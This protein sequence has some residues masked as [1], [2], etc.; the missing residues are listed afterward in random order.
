[1][2]IRNTIL[3]T[4]IAAA[5]TLFQGCSDDDQKMPANPDAPV[6]VTDATDDIIYE[7]NPRFYGSSDCLKAVNNDLDNIA[8]TGANVIWLM[9]VNTPGQLNS[10]G[11]PYCVSDFKGVNPKFG[12][13]DDLKNLVAN[14]HSRGMKVILDWIANHTAWDCAWIEDH[15]DWY[16]Q[17]GAGNIISPAGTSWTDVADL[18]YDN[19]AMRQAMI[20]AMTYW[21]TAAD[22]DGYRC[23][24]VDGVP[25]DFWT[26]AI[27]ALREKKAD[28]FMLA[29]SSDPAYFDAGFDMNYGWN[30]SSK[31][32][33][34][35]N[36]KINASKLI[37]ESAKD[38]NAL[39]DG[40][41]S[42]RYA[43]NHDVAA[44]KSASALYGSDDAMMAAQV[45]AAMLDASP[46]VYSGQ[47]V[48]Y[49]GTLSFFDYSAKTFNQAKINELKAIAAAYKAT[50]AQRCGQ[51][52]NYQAGNAL[53]FGRAVA[54]SQVLVIVN[55]TN[56]ALTVK[57]PIALAASSMTDALT[58]QSTVLPVAV[59]LQPYDYLIYYK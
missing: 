24:H 18:N 4:T 19:S 5:G 45:V 34:F 40:R 11:S 22:I 50:R 17:D 3:F 1:M 20:D 25:V 35:F 13:L 10:V 2:N 32:S 6:A 8:A 42:L 27:K 36:G 44:E 38:I 57:T 14:A 49:S 29:E 33:D 46:M 58:G 26:D 31:I 54:D 7:V 51:I 9:P 12:S 53:M 21:V 56:K 47:V 52:I 28:F 43:L 30:F 23:D 15:K 48:D 59:E 41:R 55:P 16:T 37:E 39:P